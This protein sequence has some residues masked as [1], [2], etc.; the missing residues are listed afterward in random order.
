M[1]LLR[2]PTTEVLSLR[3][4]SHEA[5]SGE[6]VQIGVP[7]CGVKSNLGAVSVHGAQEVHR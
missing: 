5:T 7:R 3:L 2:W 6:A 1:A 4:L